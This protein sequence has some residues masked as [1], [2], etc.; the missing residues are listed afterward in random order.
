ME[1]KE[2]P[3][4]EELLERIKTI[5]QEADESQG[6]TLFRNVEDIEFNE[7]LPDFLKGETIE[8]VE[9]STDEDDGNLNDVG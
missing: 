6:D 8:K 3:D 4:Y 7:E 5:R 1:F 9:A 2:L